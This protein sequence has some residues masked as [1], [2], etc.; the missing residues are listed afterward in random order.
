[1]TEIAFAHKDFFSK[2]LQ[3]NVNVNAGVNHI[4]H[5]ADT[6]SFLCI[7]LE[8]RRI[9]VSAFTREEDANASKR[10]SAAHISRELELFFR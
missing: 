5:M 1:M 7:G 9:L 4:Y 10:L 6:H 2:I 3:G 8:S